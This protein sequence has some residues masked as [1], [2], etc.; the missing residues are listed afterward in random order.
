MF[1]EGSTVRSLLNCF[2][3]AVSKALQYG[4]PLEEFVDSFTFTR[5]E[6]SGLVQGHPYI[7][8]CTS[9]LD[10]VFRVLAI[11]YLGREDLVHV[12]PE[13]TDQLQLNLVMVPK[14]GLKNHQGENGNGKEAAGLPPSAES[15]PSEPAPEP[16]GEGEPVAAGQAG[17][18]AHEKKAPQRPVIE[19]GETPLPKAE[20]DQQLA[21]LMGDAPPCEVCG[22]LTVRNATCYRCLNCGH[23]MGCS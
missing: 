7:K 23:S 1:K 6:P 14:N 5:F 18:A 12:P 10:F 22:H 21:Q 19:V 17:A 8:R 4:V 16:A 3:V 11:E 13:D 9:I 2:A 15:A 20:L